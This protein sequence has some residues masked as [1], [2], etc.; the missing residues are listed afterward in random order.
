MKKI[1]L[2]LAFFFL[3]VA[4]SFATP[5]QPT[6]PWVSAGFKNDSKPTFMDKV[7]HRLHQIWYDGTTDLYVTGYAWHNRFT[8]GSARI[9][10][11]QWNEFAE[12]GGLGRGFYDEDGDWHALYAIGFSD[13]HYNFQPVVGYGFLKMLHLPKTLN[14]GGGFTWFATERKDIFYGIPF[15]GIPLP[16]VSVGIWRISLYAT[17]VPGNTNAGNILFMFGKLTLT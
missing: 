13:S 4:N 7:Q 9:Q 10:R 3:I 6:T 12:G 2:W 16:M 8:Y 15:I 14:L 5:N 11:A 1:P 17:Y